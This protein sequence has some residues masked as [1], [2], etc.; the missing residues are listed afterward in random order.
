MRPIYAGGAMDDSLDAKRAVPMAVD[1]I[2]EVH[3]LVTGITDI[4][5]Y[6]YFDTWKKT[7]DMYTS[8]DWIK[9]MEK[10]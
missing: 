3:P 9:I 2:P 6:S 8:S 1:C 5:V 4:T 7:Y 10:R